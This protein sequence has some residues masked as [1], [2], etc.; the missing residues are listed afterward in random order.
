MNSYKNTAH[1]HIFVF[2]VTHITTYACMYAPSS[3]EITKYVCSMQQRSSKQMSAS[4]ISAANLLSF[5][6]KLVH[7]ARPHQEVNPLQWSIQFHITHSTS[8][9]SVPLL[10]LTVSFLHLKDKKE[11]EK[12]WGL[13]SRKFHIMGRFVRLFQCCVWSDLAYA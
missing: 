8:L 6:C 2:L 11:A 10:F 5:F 1:R 12:K 13:Q 9:L 4:Y 7:P 3:S